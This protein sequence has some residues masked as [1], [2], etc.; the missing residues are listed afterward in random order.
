MRPLRITTHTVTAKMYRA[1]DGKTVRER[2]CQKEG[3]PPIP[4][5]VGVVTEVYG[6]FTDISRTEEMACLLGA[7]P[8]CRGVEIVTKPWSEAPE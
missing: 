6:P 4:Q 7:K 2:M 3:D 5:V 8:E 1:V